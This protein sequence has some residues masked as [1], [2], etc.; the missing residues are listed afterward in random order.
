MLDRLN[1]THSA[2]DI[3][4]DSGAIVLK[5]CYNLRMEHV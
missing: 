5:N 3:C 2:L 4:L 1:F